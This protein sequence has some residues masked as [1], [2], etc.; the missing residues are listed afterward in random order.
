M[1][2]PRSASF[3]GLRGEK[4]GPVTN[5]NVFIKSRWRE[6][7]TSASLYGHCCARDKPPET[8]K[9]RTHICPALRQ[10]NG[11][12]A[13]GGSQSIANC[14]LTAAGNSACGH[15]RTH[16]LSARR[17]T[18]SYQIASSG[19]DYFGEWMSILNRLGPPKNP[20]STNLSPRTPCTSQK[21]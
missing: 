2:R 14:A 1:E 13:N 5:V 19:T 18:S 17:P 6:F 3:S 20:T 16:K 10:A 15:R 7:L 8:G 11:P 9:T 21:S 4:I 12:D